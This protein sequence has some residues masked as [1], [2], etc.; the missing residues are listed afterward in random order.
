[1]PKISV[2][3]SVYNS[4]AFLEEAVD[5]I[6]SQA[7]SDF[8]FIIVN[9]GS[10]DESGDILTSLAEKDKRIQLIQNEEN[11]GLTRSLN[12]GLV[13]AKGEYIARDGCG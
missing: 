5:S 10:T 11:I 3:M 1:M 6:L 9:D 8:E 4:A 2:L 13:Q 7:F 12:K